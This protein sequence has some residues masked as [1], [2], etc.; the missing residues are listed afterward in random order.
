MNKRRNLC[1]VKKAAKE[2]PIL[3][4]KVIELRCPEGTKDELTEMLRQG[5][6][7]LIEQAVEAEF[8]EFLAVN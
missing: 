8:R 4:S 6:R 3:K 5:A 2:T 7:E 1:V